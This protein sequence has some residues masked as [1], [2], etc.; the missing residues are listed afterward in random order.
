MKLCAR[1]EKLARRA[2]GKSVTGL[3]KSTVKTRGKDAGN[4]VAR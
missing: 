4:E 2:V 3:T 1:M